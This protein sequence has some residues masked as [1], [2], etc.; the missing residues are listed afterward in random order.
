MFLARMATTIT[1]GQL[2]MAAE[3]LMAHNATADFMGTILT[4]YPLTINTGRGQ[5]IF[6]GQVTVMAKVEALGRAVTYLALQRL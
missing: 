3:W 5:A 1:A 2:T 6:V 4:K